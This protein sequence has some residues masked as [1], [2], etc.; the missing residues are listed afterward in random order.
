MEPTQSLMNLL[1]NEIIRQVLGHL[2]DKQRINVSRVSSIWKFL[3]DT[4]PNT[5]KVRS[6]PVDFPETYDTYL[7]LKNFKT[8]SSFEK[9]ISNLSKIISK[10]EKILIYIATK[11][12]VDYS[13]VRNLINN[14][15]KGDSA[16]NEVSDN[17]LLRILY[18]FVSRI[19]P[20]S[21]ITD[22]FN[23]F[24][25][26]GAYVDRPFIF[27]PNASYIPPSF[28]V[29]KEGDLINYAKKLEFVP[30]LSELVQKEINFEVPDTLESKQ[31][32]LQK[33]IQGKALLSVEVFAQ[34]IAELLPFEG[35]NKLKEY[36]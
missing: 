27:F 22:L 26:G 12:N 21:L 31:A 10:N 34:T 1:P 19:P 32:L 2:T 7:L 29:E 14:E 4:F 25:H 35:D 13:S 5:S 23:H 28:I 36:Q 8:T 18:C 3:G 16:L 30:F 33:C 15:I 24:V 17:I 6:W 11:F 20:T 9:D